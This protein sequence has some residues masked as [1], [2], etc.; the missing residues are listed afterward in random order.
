MYLLILF[1]YFILELTIEKEKEK[2]EV[3]S[4]LTAQKHL[5]EYLRK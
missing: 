5:Y 2:R 1:Y 4:F 3:N